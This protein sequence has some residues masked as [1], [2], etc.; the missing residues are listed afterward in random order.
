LAA[1][2]PYPVNLIA[3]KPKRENVS[4]SIGHGATALR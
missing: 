4:I 3:A 2:A 1:F